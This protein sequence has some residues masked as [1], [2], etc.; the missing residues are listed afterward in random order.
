MLFCRYV[1]GVPFVDGIKADT[2]RVHFLLKMLFKKRGK[3]LVPALE[4]VLSRVFLS[5]IHA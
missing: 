2:K 4:S 1:E 3:G 5:A